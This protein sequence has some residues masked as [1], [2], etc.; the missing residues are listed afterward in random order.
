MPATLREVAR[1]AGVSVTTAS[2]VVNGSSA[3]APKTMARVREVIERLDYRPNGSARAL[4]GGR[5]GLLSLVLP[6]FG[7]PAVTA[8]T[9]GVVEAADARGYQVIVEQTGGDRDR[10][11]AAAQGARR[12]MTDGQILLPSAPTDLDAAAL[13]AAGP[14]VL[15]G[16]APG[17]DTVDRVAERH[18]D[19]AEAGLQH[20]ASWGHRV[21]GLV[22]PGT[23]PRRGAVDL[24]GDGYRR[25]VARA[26]GTVDPQLVERAAG[27]DRVDGA[28]AVATL[29]DRRP[30]IT[31]VFALSDAL[32]LGALAEI[33]RRGRSAPEHL[34][35]LGW[36]DLDEGLFHTPA[37]STIDG[38]RR[39]LAGL[40][41]D[42]LLSRIERP[43]APA[44]VVS[45][46]YRVL[47]RGST[48]WAG[49]D[50]RR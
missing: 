35:V 33:A 34:S 7:H 24:R 48:A 25:A 11:R 6:D 28:L 20:L 10:E 12:Q 26:G 1:A 40:A 47:Q 41:V 8:L 30:D 38:G 44:R 39:E 5:T 49:T 36:D 37:L 32:A 50:A 22:E 13:R 18:D 21:I 46:P 17:L 23:D 29:L 3:V 27:G 42:A 15:L 2:A 4:R 31:A 16:G 9:A 45:A 43:D 19:A 14:T